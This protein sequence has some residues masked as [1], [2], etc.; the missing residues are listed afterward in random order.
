[1]RRATIMPGV[2]RVTAG[3]RRRLV[4]AEPAG[5]TPPKTIPI[6]YTWPERGAI[7]ELFRAA[8]KYR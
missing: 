1:M 3:Q 8:R 7:N 2:V 5:R 6:G 4:A